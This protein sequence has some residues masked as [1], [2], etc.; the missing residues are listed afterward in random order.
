MIRMMLKLIGVPQIEQVY[1][2][3]IVPQ[4]SIV[5]KVKSR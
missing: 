3:K 1:E 5:L 2:L 4:I